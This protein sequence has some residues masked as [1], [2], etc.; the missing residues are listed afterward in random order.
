MSQERSLGAGPR[1]KRDL[2]YL[3]A[4]EENG[5]EP[6]HF[7]EFIG[8]FKK[9]LMGFLF[10]PITTDSEGGCHGED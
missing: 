10:G 6:K 8:E 1:R 7:S 3:S 4:T 2:E 9:S 5:K